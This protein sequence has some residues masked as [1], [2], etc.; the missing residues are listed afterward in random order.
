M[1]GQLCNT[2]LNEFNSQRTHCISILRGEYTNHKLGRGINRR[3]RV[4][5]PVLLTTTWYYCL[6]FNMLLS[7]VV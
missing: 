4:E 3:R 6:V 7:F 2:L 5:D 1:A